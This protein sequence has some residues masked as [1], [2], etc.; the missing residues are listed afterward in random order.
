[1]ASLRFITGNLKTKY[2]NLCMCTHS[3]GKRPVCPGRLSFGYMAVGNIGHHFL[4]WALADL[5]CNR[6]SPWLLASSPAEARRAQS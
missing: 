6:W 3:K 1:M 2:A 5:V 4:V